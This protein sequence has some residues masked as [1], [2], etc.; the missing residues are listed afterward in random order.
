MV[1][2]IQE[3]QDLLKEPPSERRPHYIGRPLFEENSLKGKN[4]NICDKI[5]RRWCIDHNITVEYFSEAYQIYAR[6][7][8][9]M[10]PTK[11]PHQRTNL[12]KALKT[13][14][15]TW[16]RFDMALFRVLGFRLED[17]V[18]HMR[19]TEKDDLESIR[20]STCTPK[21]VFTKR[22]GNHGCAHD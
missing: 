1:Q 4:L 18:F 19:R 15:I 21:V 2:M 7:I 9:L 5:L 3:V 22:S 20:L 8:L 10:H 13:G 14:G 6:D 16:K 12:M 11:I 17:V